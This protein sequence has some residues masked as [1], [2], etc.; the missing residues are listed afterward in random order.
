MLA[1]LQHLGVPA[2]ANV[3]SQPAAAAAAA[4]VCRSCRCPCRSCCRCL[5][6]RGWVCSPGGVGGRGVAVDGQNAVAARGLHVQLVAAHLAVLHTHTHNLQQRAAL[7]TPR[8]PRSV[9]SAL[10]TPLPPRSMLHACPCPQKLPLHARNL[11][12]TRWDLPHL[13]HGALLAAR[14]HAQALQCTHTRPPQPMA[15]GPRGHSMSPARRLPGKGTAAAAGATPHL[16]VEAVGRVKLDR[17]AGA[18]LR[19]EVHE[20]KHALI[21][22]FQVGS[23][24]SVLGVPAIVGLQ[25]VYKAGRRC[26]VSGAGCA[27]GAQAQEM[28]GGRGL[29]SG[30]SLDGWLCCRTL[31]ACCAAC[32]GLH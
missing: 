19:S 22:D 14:H 7:S 5:P 6:R 12:G 31:G 10:S 21:V 32:I 20:V 23:L 17:Q 3:P 4:C 15:A 29:L 2:T 27:G 24:Q 9:H 18:L 13:H 26:W 1:C 28:E 8:P 11:Q 25:P 30:R 16:H